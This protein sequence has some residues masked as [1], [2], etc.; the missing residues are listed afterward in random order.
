MLAVTLTA[1]G[2]SKPPVG[3]FVLVLDTTEVSM[4]PGGEASVEVRVDP[5][6]GFD[7]TVAFRLDDVASGLDVTLDDAGDGTAT[8][9]VRSGA[10]TPDGRYEVSL[11]ARGGGRSHDAVVTVVVAP[12]RAQVFAIDTAATVSA[13]DATVTYDPSTATFA[14]IGVPNP[15]LLAAVYDDGEGTL[16]V[17]VLTLE[18]VKGRL[19]ELA[20]RVTEGDAP[21]LSGHLAFDASSEP[22]EAE[23]SLNPLDADTVSEPYD[24]G[25]RLDEIVGGRP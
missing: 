13:V 11:S 6:E 19:V 17:R 5:R 21:A 10:D 1:C 8:L 2:G 4:L 14:E 12:A 18:P 24:V 16:E 9:D 7:A 15:A 25:E 23:L 3:D 22:V 20:F